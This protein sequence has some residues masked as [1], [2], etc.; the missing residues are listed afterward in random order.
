MVAGCASE[1]RRRWGSPPCGDPPRLRS[2]L[3]Q[4]KASFLEKRVEWRHSSC[5][6]K[7]GKRCRVRGR[8]LLGKREEGRTHRLSWSTLKDRSGLYFRRKVAHPVRFGFWRATALSMDRGFDRLPQSIV[9]SLCDYDS[10]YLLARRP[11]HNIVPQGQITI[12][13]AVAS[14]PLT[15]SLTM[16]VISEPHATCGDSLVPQMK[17]PSLLTGATPCV[18][19]AA[20]RV[21]E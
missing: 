20:V 3:R 13:V 15:E 12:V 17:E 1:W 10:P 18:T 4:N 11:Y 5:L 7:Y 16:A 2:G 6:V 21:P 19:T 9:D 14:R 8:P